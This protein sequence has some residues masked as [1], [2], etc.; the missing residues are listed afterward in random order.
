MNIA[1]DG[2]IGAVT[3]GDDI[4]PVTTD[5]NNDF[6]GLGPGHMA[7]GFFTTA[8]GTVNVIT[9]AG[10]TRAIPVVA[11]KDYLV[12][13]KRFLTSSAGNIWAF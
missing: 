5:D 13:V 8:D 4:C 9:A 11:Q 7:R 3:A 10:Q 12:K 6:T 1:K 2:T